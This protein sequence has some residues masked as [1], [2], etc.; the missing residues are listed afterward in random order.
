MMVH[1][2]NKDEQNNDVSLRS[3]WYYNVIG[4]HDGGTCWIMLLELN[5]DLHNSGQNNDVKTK[6][7]LMI[8]YQ[9][10]STRN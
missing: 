9:K 7:F 3:K 8:C 10:H 4:R 1:T 5:N 6:K 2:D